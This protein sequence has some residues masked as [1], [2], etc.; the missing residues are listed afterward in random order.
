GPPLLGLSVYTRDGHRLGRVK[1][2]RHGCFLVDVRF[3]F[4]YW[5]PLRCVAQQTAQRLLLVLAKRDIADYLVDIDCP[6]DLEQLPPLPHDASPSAA[7]PAAL[8]RSRWL[9]RVRGRRETRTAG[10]PHP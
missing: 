10:T 6:T 9:P 5:L 1:T 7:G 8:P 3:A 4:D 2:I